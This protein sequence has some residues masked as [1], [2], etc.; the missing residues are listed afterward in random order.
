M[1]RLLGLESRTA[2]TSIYSEK[3]EIKSRRQLLAF[4]A[5]HQRTRRR[6]AITDLCVGGAMI[7]RLR[8]HGTGTGH[9]RPCVGW[10]M[11]EPLKTAHNSPFCC[12][13]LF[14][15][16]HFSSSVMTP[17]TQGRWW[18]RIHFNVWFS[19]LSVAVSPSV[20]HRFFSTS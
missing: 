11:T 4:W 6:W 7:E 20:W 9:H 19:H 18:S 16:S 3:P 17:P 15:L 10:A 8:R 1:L 14:K 2:R 12:Y 13:Y 5:L